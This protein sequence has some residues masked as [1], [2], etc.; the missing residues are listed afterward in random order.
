MKSAVGAPE[1]D[2]EARAAPDAADSSCA[3]RRAGDVTPLDPARSVPPAM[4]Q[5]PVGADR[6]HVDAVGVPRSG[7][8]VSRERAAEGLPRVPGRSVPVAV[9]DLAV[10]VKSEDLGL[11]GRT[12]RCG[13]GSGA[14]RAAEWGPVR[15]YLMRPCFLSHAV[16]TALLS[17]L[18]TATCLF[19]SFSSAWLSFALI[20]F[21]RRLSV[22]SSFWRS[23]LRTTGAMLSASCRCLSSSRSTKF[24]A[25]ML[26]S[27][28]KRRPT[29]ICLPSSAAIV[30][31]PPVSSGLKSLNVMPYVFL[32]PSAQ[33]GRCGH[34]G[35]P[36]S[37]RVLPIGARSLSFFKDFALAVACVT[38]NPF[39]SVACAK[40]STVRLLGSS[41]FCRPVC[42]SFGSVV[43]LAT[44]PSLS[45]NASSVARYS[46]STSICPDSIAG[47]TI[48]RLPRLN[49][50]VTL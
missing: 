5:Y 19:M 39:W 3:A 30:S 11:A 12:P 27:L 20:E 29:S 17:A 46:A 2:V 33:N 38:T 35:G 47:S 6:E 42:V 24:L 26:G 16:A 28:V 23:A 48:S 22:P 8:R 9:P 34:S 43:G 14:E 50:R 32:R 1:K 10:L 4:A 37:T 44:L 21:R 13:G 18:S 40:S 31:G 41:A 25:T 15:A 45:T 49:L 7:G 36:P